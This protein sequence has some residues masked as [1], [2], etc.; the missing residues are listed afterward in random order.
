MVVFKKTVLIEK[1]KHNPMSLAGQCAHLT[2]DPG[3]LI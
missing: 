3:G 2:E 1:G